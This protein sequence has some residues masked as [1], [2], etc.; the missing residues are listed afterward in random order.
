MIDTMLGS[1]TMRDTKT[2]STNRWWWRTSSPRCAF[3]IISMLAGMLMALQLVHWN[4]LAGHRTV[5]A[6]PL[7]DGPH[8]CHRLWLSGQR[9]PGRAALGD[10][11]ADAADR[12]WTG[13]CVGSSSWPG[14]SWYCPRPSGIVVGP[15][16]QAASPVL[17]ALPFSF[18]AQGLEWGETPTWIDPLALV[19]LLLVAINFMAPISRAKGPLYVACW[20]FMAAFVW[21]FLTYAMGNFLP[22]VL[23]HRHQ[24]RRRRRAV[25]SRPGGT[26]R[27]AAGLGIDVLLRADHAAQADLESRAVAGR[28]LGVGVLL[29]AQRHSPFPV[30]AHSDVP[31]ARGDHRDRGRGDGG[32][33]GDH[34]L[35][36]HDLGIGAAA[37]HQSAHSLV[38]YRHGLLR[39]HVYAVR[40]ASDADVSGRDSLQRLGRGARPPGDVRRLQHVVAGH[41]DLPVSAPVAHRVVQPR[42]VRMALLAVGRGR[43]RDGG[44]SDPGRL[45]SRLLLGLA[46]AVGRFGR[47]VAAVLDAARLCRPGDVRRPVVFRSTT[48][49]ARGKRRDWGRPRSR[50]LRPRPCHKPLES[51]LV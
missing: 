42:A 18:G 1:R 35:L 4:P 24:R 47:R 3:L 22:R 5:V 19:G 13:G 39:D 9:V 6:R 36:R 48:C 27:H 21:T 37:R 32:D 20:Y 34:Q 15:T 44:R 46:A 29:S 31:A 12:C 33:H 7:A 30:H 45:V 10:S 23:A 50:R 43:G 41:H 38:L 11:A 26:V 49:T 16:L 17:E 51:G 40:H 2:W 14:R 25:H 8:Q 28:L